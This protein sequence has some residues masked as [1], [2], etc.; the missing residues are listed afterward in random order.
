MNKHI[1][2]FEK[3]TSI[4]H[5]D[6]N[7]WHHY[8]CWLELKNEQLYKKNEQLKKTYKKLEMKMYLEVNKIVKQRNQLKKI[9]LK[10]LEDLILAVSLQATNCRDW[11]GHIEDYKKQIEEI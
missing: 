6:N 3:E 10:I 9:A 5:G 11:D 4:K 8:R 1:E 2:Q 7:F